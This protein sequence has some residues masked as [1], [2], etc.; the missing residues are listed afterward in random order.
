MSCLPHVSTRA[1]K[2][3]INKIIQLILY[4]IMPSLLILTFT[5]FM[6]IKISISLSLFDLYNSQSTALSHRSSNEIVLRPD[7]VGYQFQLV[8]LKLN[9]TFLVCYHNTLE[10]GVW[11]WKIEKDFNEDCLLV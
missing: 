1:K 8:H 2:S 9:D 4:Q 11:S 7:G 10:T 3:L 5:L 6:S